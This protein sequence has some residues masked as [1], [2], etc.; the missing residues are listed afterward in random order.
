MTLWAWTIMFCTSTGL[1]LSVWCHDAKK[2]AKSANLLL[3]NWENT[4][5]TPERRYWPLISNPH[6][7]VCTS[8]WTQ[9][10]CAGCLFRL[11]RGRCKDS[12]TLEQERRRNLLQHLYDFLYWNS[13]NIDAAVIICTIE[14]NSHL[15]ISGKPTHLKKTRLP[16]VSTFHLMM[17][18]VDN[19]TIMSCWCWMAFIVLKITKLLG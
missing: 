10:A 16:Q 7:S 19:Y 14:G 2:N 11:H 13:A 8:V 9:C 18:D 12:Y 1:H 3:F 4:T 15:F 17:L 6:P 5:P